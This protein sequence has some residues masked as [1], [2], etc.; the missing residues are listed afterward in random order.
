M[1]PIR[2]RQGVGTTTTGGMKADQSTVR[3]V[4]AG[5]ECSVAIELTAE[6]AWSVMADTH[7]KNTA[8]RLP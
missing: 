5:Q 7:D 4:V 8:G 1:R 3:L 6:G 2:A